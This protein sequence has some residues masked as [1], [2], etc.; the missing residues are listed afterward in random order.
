MFPVTFIQKTME[1]LYISKNSEILYAD[2]Q[3]TKKKKHLLWGDTVYV[4]NKNTGLAGIYQVKSRGL[5]GYLKSS[6]LQAESLLEVY[7]IDVGQGDGVLI[8]TPDSK[9]ILVDGGYNRK[10]QQSGKNAADF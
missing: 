5:D 6:S 7:F 8:K 10:K 1:T 2:P 4:I 9:H 3:L